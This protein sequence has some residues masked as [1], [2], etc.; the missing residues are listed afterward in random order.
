MA[1]PGQWVNSPR[2]S[3][4]E[5][6]ALRKRARLAGYN[7]P[8]CPVSQPANGSRPRQRSARNLR[9]PRGGRASGANGQEVAPDCPVRHRTVRCVRR[10]S[11]ANG[12]LGPIWK[13]IATVQ[14]PVRHRTVRCTTAQKANR[15]LPIGGAMAPWPLGAIKEAPKR[16]YQT[17]KHTLSTLQ[18]RDSATTS[19][20]H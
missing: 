7:S 8:D 1:Y 20:I 5:L 17:H 4:A 15:R 12:R 3:V 18:L 6:A 2:P 11:A 9:R 13:E 16:L 14:C 19:L 10:G